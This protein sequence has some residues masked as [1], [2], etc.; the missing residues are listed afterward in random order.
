VTLRLRNQLDQ[1]RR[2]SNSL[3]DQLAQSNKMASLG[4]M[5]SG[6]AHELRNPLGIITSN[7]QLLDEHPDDS[8][9]R[10]MCVQKICTAARRASR[11]ID[12]LLH[13]AHPQ[14][15]WTHVVDLRVLLDETLLAL[16]QQLAAQWVRV[17]HHVEPDLPPIR[18]N[19]ELLQQVFTNL[20][21]NACNAM[22][23][24]GVLT[25]RACRHAAA[26]RRK[27]CPRCSTHSLPRCRWAAARG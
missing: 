5:A 3:E 17:N 15:K 25:I 13:F 23:G 1:R 6:I 18:G 12:N 26:S 24:G 8:E 7:A 2:W 22:T 4:V 14:S 16:D 19:A 20:I 9:L 11:I 21:H 10:H 27:T